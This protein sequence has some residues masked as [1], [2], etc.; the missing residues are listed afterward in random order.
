MD[1]DDDYYAMSVVTDGYLWVRGF[2]FF[3]LR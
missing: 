1:D 2:C 3:N